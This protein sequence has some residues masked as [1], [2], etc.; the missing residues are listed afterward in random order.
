MLT[1]VAHKRKKTEHFIKFIK[2]T[3]SFKSLGFAICF[4]VCKKKKL[5]CLSRLDLFYIC[6]Y[7]TIKICFLFECNIFL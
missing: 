3:L 2:Y 5:K 4:N 1:V 6:L 7:F